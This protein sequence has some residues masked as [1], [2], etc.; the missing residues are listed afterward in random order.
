MRIRDRSL[1][2]A[3]ALSRRSLVALAGGALLSPLAARAQQRERVRRIGMLLPAAAGDSRFQTFAGA[4]LQAL[5]QSG[6]TIGRNVQIDT[7]WATANAAEIRKHAAELAALAPDVILAHG[8][9]TVGRCRRRPAPC[10]SCSRPPPI[11]SA[12]ATSKV[13]RGRTATSQAS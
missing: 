13:L 3:A 1:G 12:P 7:R 9:S 2:V 5:A 10:R 6:W 11:R 4:F 8:D